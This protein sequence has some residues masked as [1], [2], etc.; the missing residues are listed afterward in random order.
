MLRPGNAG[1]LKDN[2]Q[3]THKRK[4]KLM[5][6]QVDQWTQHPPDSVAF[7]GMRVGAG[8]AGTAVRGVGSP[9]GTGP[10]GVSSRAETR[11]DHAGGQIEG[12]LGVF[13]WGSWR[14]REEHGARSVGHGSA[15]GR[16]GRTW[17]RFG[18]R[19]E[20][21]GGLCLT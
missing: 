16:F 9:G 3:N 19:L 7:H 4:S 11:Q 10:C 12:G 8:A 6:S 1:A 14:G 15:P 13:D 17:Q 18:R 21:V 5:D 20:P 2:S